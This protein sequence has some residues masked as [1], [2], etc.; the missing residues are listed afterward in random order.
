MSKN[1]IEKIFYEAMWFSDTDSDEPIVRGY[2]VEGIL[3]KLLSITKNDEGYIE[4]Y[5]FTHW[6]G[7][8]KT[9]LHKKYCVRSDLEFHELNRKSVREE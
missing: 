4:I 8:Y 3:K 6:D 5:K 1:Q 7:G 2:D 9:N